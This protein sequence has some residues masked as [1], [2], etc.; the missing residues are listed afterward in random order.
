MQWDT[1]MSLSMT[2]SF[3]GTFPSVQSCQARKIDHTDDLCQTSS[4]LCLKQ[5]LGC[6]DIASRHNRND[7]AHLSLQCSIQ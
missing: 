6:F 7:L 3:L 2:I 5:W 1:R 4:V